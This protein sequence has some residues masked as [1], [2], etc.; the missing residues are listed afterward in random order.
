MDDLIE[1][2]VRLMNNNIGF[3]GPVNIGNPTEFTILQLATKIL[4]LIPESKS[5]IVYKPLPSDDPIQRQPDISVAREK[6]DWTPKVALDNGL[7]KTIEYFRQ[8][9]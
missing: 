3:T 8:V 6:L 1:G 5:K 4:E 7:R 2:M 9:V